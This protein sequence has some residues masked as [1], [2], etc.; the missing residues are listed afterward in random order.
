MGEARSPATQRHP[1]RKSQPTRLTP[2]QGLGRVHRPRHQ[3][4]VR[5]TRR[6]RLYA[7]GL[8]RTEE[9]SCH[10]HQ[11][12]PRAQGRTPLSPLR[13][14]RLLRLQAFQPGERLPTKQG[15][16]SD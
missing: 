2:E 8:L 15:E 6:P 10:R 7:L 13:L 3:G 12:A 11:E 4:V 5:Q 9:R 16:E 14:P 1:N